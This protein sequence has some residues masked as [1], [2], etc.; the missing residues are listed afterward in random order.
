MKKEGSRPEP[1]ASA[2]GRFGR[3][4]YGVKS[5]HGAMKVLLIHVR[6]P[7]FYAIPSKKRGKNGRIQVMGFPPIGIM[8]L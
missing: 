6:D 7:Q 4:A 1:I 8:S 3:G 2:G 5:V